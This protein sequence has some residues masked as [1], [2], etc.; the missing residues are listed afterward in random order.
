[1]KIEKHYKIA[2]ITCWYG[3]YPWYFPYFIHSCSY[4]STIEFFIITDNKE[5]IK[6]KPENVHIVYKTI[7]EIKEIAYNKLGFQ[8]SL[9]YPY[10]FCDFKPTYGFLFP[11]IINNY[12]YWGYTDLDII[13]GDIRYFFS[14]EMLEK[15]DFI[16]VRHDYTSGCF[17]LYRNCEKMNRFFMRSKDY[18]LVLSSHEHFCFDECNFM[19]DELT[20][21]SK[22]ILDLHTEIES[23][24]HIIKIAELNK[25]V[26]AHFD[27][28]LME[29]KAGRVV[30]DNGKI[31][32]KDMF[33]AILYH[34]VWLKKVYNP[35]SIPQNIPDKYYISPTR[36]YH[37][38]KAKVKQDLSV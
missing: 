15:Y 32:Y 30:F 36:I 27:F 8:V 5:F 1:M 37:Y 9:E 38:R 17:A 14:N 34:L 4:N 29:G 3:V 18:K 10:K 6:A 31:I 11:E 22:S 20:D 2:M 35:I 7:N 23:F 16:S 21:G 25:E 19:W 13:Y 33:E 28:I 12:D 24:T 26:R